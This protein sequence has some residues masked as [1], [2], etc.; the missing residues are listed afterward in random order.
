MIFDKSKLSSLMI[1]PNQI[2]T[3][4]RDKGLS[5]FYQQELGA[6]YRTGQRNKCLGAASS[7]LTEPEI[8]RVGQDLRKSVIDE[9]ANKY[10]HT[11]YRVLFHMPPVGVGVT[12]FKDLMECLEHTGIPCTAVPM[13]STDLKIRWEAFHPNVFISMDLPKVLRSLDLDFILNY[14]KQS[15]CCR[16]F[17]P[18]TKYHFPKSGMST[19]D[20]WRLGIAQKGQ[21]A[22]AFFCM[23]APE[24]F[25]EFFAE[26]VQSGF[27]YLSLPNGS[28]PFRHY[29]VNGVKE[30]DFFVVTSF[31]VDRAQVTRQ[32]LKPI[33]ENYYGLWAG[34]GWK[35]GKKEIGAASLRD[36]YARVCISTNPLMPFLTRYQAETTERSFTATACGAFQITNWTPVTDR[37]FPEDEL[38]CVNSPKEFYDT[39]IYY[40]SQPGERNQIVMRG[41]K[42][43]FQEHTYFHRIDQFVNF[44]E[45]HKDLF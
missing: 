37:F 29:P 24:W 33:L 20:H 6:S 25:D 11:G 2:L 36:Y 22:D 31:S 12:W 23:M 8:V 15:G 32:Y 44:L 42:R 9:Y 41:M 45:N 1:S 30:W 43:V 21:S 7:E 26:W 34:T 14:K 38:A 19:Q 5:Y 35:F 3:K 17:T 39:F 28:N 16:L 40:L 18:I 4:V 27:T 13:S 10:S